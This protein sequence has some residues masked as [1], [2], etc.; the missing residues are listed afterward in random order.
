M[1]YVIVGAGGFAGIGKHD[2]AI[3]V[4]QIKER[5]G[6]LVM[7]G[8]TPASIKA[9]P[10][11]HYMTAGSSRDQFIA[12]ADKDI[13]HAKAKVAELEKQAGATATD[14]KMRIDQRIV[15]L[16]ED[17][18]SAEG[19]LTE[20]KQATA[21]NWKTFEGDV[22]AATARLRKSIDTATS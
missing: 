4:A 11:F 2:V 7:L 15:A 13:A 12:A 19:K 3:P 21:A 17:L 10:A 18:K 5:D 22:S 1:S 14:A 6:K 16:K 8:A 20:L 9:M